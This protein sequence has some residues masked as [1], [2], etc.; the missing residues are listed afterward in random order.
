MKQSK[1]IFRRMLINNWGGISHKVMEFHEYVNLF[2]GKSGSGKSTVMDAIQVILYGSV[3][4][5]FLNKAADDAKNK[6]SVLS[7]LRGAQ[8]DGTSNR[9]NVDFCSQIVLELEDTGSRLFTCI[10]AVFEVGSQDTELRKYHFFSHSGQFPEDG[11]LTEQGVPYTTSQMKKLIEARSHSKDNRG[12]VEVNRTYPSREAYLGTLYDSIFGYIDPGRLMT[13]E[14]SAIALRMAD[15]TGQFIKDYMFPKSKEDTVSAISRQLGAYREIKEKVDDLEHRI[16]ILDEVHNTNQELVRIRA[17]RLRAETVLRIVDIESC[18]TRL[19]AKKE[20]LEAISVKISG[21]EE[22]YGSLDADK[23]EKTEELIEVKAELHS[24]DYGVKQKEMEELKTTIGLLK[25]NSRQWQEIL[26][27]L[28]EWETNEEISGYISNPAL[29]CLE[30]ILDGEISESAL[31]K[32]RAGIQNAMEMI[33]EELA[34]LNDSIR[35]TAR[36]LSEK[37]EMA[38]DLKNDRKP[39]RK[40]LKSARAQLQSELS[41][42]YGRTIHVEI[43]ADLFDIVDEKWKDAVEGRLG[44][45]KHSLVTEPQYALDA[46]RIFRRMK[47]KEYEEVDLIN[48][49]A[50]KRDGPA[51]EAGT[52]YE[53]VRAGEPYA[54]L[55]LRRY[56]GRIFKCESVEELHAVRDGVTP[57]CYSYS[58][59][60]FRHLREDDYR[61]FSCIGTKVSKAKLKELEEEI[62]QLEQRQIGDMQ[63]RET[64]NRAQ[65]FE[66]LHQST[67]QLLQLAQASRELENYLDKQEQLAKELKELEDGTMT[68][69]LK[70]QKEILEQG[71]QEL[72]RMLEQVNK[73][74]IGREGDLRA[75]QKEYGDFQDRLSALQ[76]GFRADDRLL[77]E[78]REG[79]EIQS[80]AAYRRKQHD[81]CQRLAGQEEEQ[82]EQRIL[83]RNRFNREYPAYGFSGV[84]HENAVYDKLWEE[85]KRDYVPQYK[86]DFEN[87]YRQVYHSLRENVIATIHGEIKAA[88]RHRREINRML[89]RIRFSDSTYQI[90]ILPAENENGQFYEML[91]APELDSK[92]LDNDGFEGQLSIGEDA[93]F[94]KYEQQIQRLTEKFMPPRDG[95]GDNRSRHNQEMERYAD[96]RNYLTFSM[97]ERVEDDQG[98]VKKNAVDEMAGRDSGGEGQN[99]KYVALLAGFAMLYMQQS[100]RDSKIRLVLLDEAFSKMDKERSEVCLRYA[101]ELELQLIVCVPDERL[102]SLIRN[103]DSVYGFRR[104]QNQISMMH[105]DRGEYLELMDGGGRNAGEY[106]ENSAEMERNE[107]IHPL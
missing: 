13:M 8:K 54:D 38:E 64:L 91:M 66:R 98:N 7:Y 61:R 69:Q 78:V 84:E 90:D 45:I 37:K 58:N 40:E 79:L 5:A 102:Q 75:A 30:E 22:R 26:Q 46:A 80:E 31:D 53:A 73:E 85:L 29:Q 103:V 57:D 97:Y 3:S 71:I 92:V 62:Y 35:G 88:Y 72:T 82:E 10:G 100:N 36:E 106:G 15:G 74:R 39:Y 50:I 52:L 42:Q 56:L 49:A 14:K 65:S 20:D 23:K 101:R 25:G 17:D 104:Y 11:Y 67:G 93:F 24:S 51:A 63:M 95:E 4:A 27:N 99:P 28:K 43:F 83:A 47:R 107:A 70:K 34:E 1:K 32:L 18:K 76:E 94:Q 6:R 2:S 9:E 19:E 21:L 55:C 81:L 48:T 16:E 87:Q 77:A 59:Y 33:G 41:S 105:I 12:R 89:S 68:A 60:I 44:R 96:Y 86:A